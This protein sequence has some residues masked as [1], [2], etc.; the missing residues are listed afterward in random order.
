MNSKLETCNLG[1]IQPNE[2]EIPQ[3]RALLYE[4]DKQHFI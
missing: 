3:T 1:Q 4:D 2:Q